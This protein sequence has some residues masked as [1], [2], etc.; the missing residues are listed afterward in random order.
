MS[1]DKREKYRQIIKKVV[2]PESARR[3]NS[4]EE[5]EKRLKE[6]L[7]SGQVW[8]VTD[9]G[10]FCHVVIRS[11]HEDPRIITVIPMSLDLK[12]ETSDSLVFMKGGI[13]QLPTVVWP[14]LARDIPTR[15]LRKPLGLIDE[16]RFRLIMGDAPDEGLSVYR[17]RE[18]DDFGYLSEVKRDRIDDFLHD[19][20]LQ[21]KLLSPL[22]SIGDRREGRRIRIGICRILMEQG[23]SRSDAETA[24]ERPSQLN[25]GSIEKLLDNGF[26]VDDL[27]KAELLPESLLCEIELPMVRETVE[28]YA[29]ENPQSPDPYLSLAKEAYG[30]AARHAKNHFGDW[31]A[32]IRK[33]RIRHHA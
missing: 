1:I 10:E 33:V 18:L 29:R 32:E 22:P 2:V 11:M 20:S 23:M 28:A 5:I 15:V 21:C 26:S 4:P 7:A 8:T 19:C 6:P 13:E 17:G 12:T 9:D 24:S 3:A 27:K 14:N 25:K 31:A 30:L 16:R